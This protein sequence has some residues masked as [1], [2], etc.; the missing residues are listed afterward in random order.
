MELTRL[1]SLPLDTQIFIAF[2][3]FVALTFHIRFNARTV[4]NGPTILTTLGIFATFFGIAIGLANFDQAN[5]QESIPH[6]LQGLKTAFWASVVGVG[7]A[8]TIKFRDQLFGHQQDPLALPG[9]DDVGAA[10]VVYGLG[11]IENALVGGEEGSLIS[12]LK[13]SRTETRDE[14]VKL[15][16]AQT[17]ALEKLSEMGSRTLIE[18]LKDVIRDFNEKLTE[19][20]GENFKELNS[21]VGKLVDWQQQYREHVEKSTN[22]L[23]A[24]HRLLAQTTLDYAQVVEKST[25]F[26]QVAQTLGITLSDLATRQE[27]LRKQSTALAD[28]LLKASGSLPEVER[29]MMEL[30]QQLSNGMSE[31]K[32][33]VDAALAEQTKSIRE[34]QQSVGKSMTDGADSLRQSMN[35]TVQAIS[36]ANEQYNKQLLELVKKTTDNIALLDEALGEELERALTSLGEQLTALSQRFVSDYQPLTESLRQV[37]SIA[38]GVNVR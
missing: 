21:A 16:E 25:G 11:R 38:R 3:L 1:Q 27:E 7:C 2:I 32:K 35:N 24:I 12:Q 23:T 6:L 15:R 14:L 37:V 22:E 10:E 31:S 29:K 28:L 9:H 26:S 17:K 30:A 34:V 20:F 8:L 4:A 33:I 13:L 18:A 36:S 5:I 19:Q